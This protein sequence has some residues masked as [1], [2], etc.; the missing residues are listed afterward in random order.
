[1]RKATLLFLLAFLVSNAFAQTVSSSLIGTVLD[2]AGAVVPNAPV[3]LT[4]LNTGSAR[5]GAT[6]TSGVFRF[7]NLTPGNYSVTV[8]VTGFK[9]LVQ[10]NIAVAA[11]ET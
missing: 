9:T 4:D 5:D 6:D 7:L 10:N 11:Q 2:P 3:T 8:R 1:M